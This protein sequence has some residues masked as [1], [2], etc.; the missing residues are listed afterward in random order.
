[1]SPRNEG[2]GDSESR[3]SSG[4]RRR[5]NRFSQVHVSCRNLEVYQKEDERQATD[6]DEDLKE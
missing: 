2:K 4:G 6:P 5:K 3:N 1:M